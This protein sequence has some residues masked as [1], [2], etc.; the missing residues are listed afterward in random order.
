MAE[1][2]SNAYEGVP[3]VSGEIPGPKGKAIME[4]FDKYRSP[5]LTVHPP[6]VWEKAN[7]AV[8]EDIDGISQRIFSGDVVLI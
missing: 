8:V 7:G 1:N 3:R 5:S 4:L 2:K 6:L